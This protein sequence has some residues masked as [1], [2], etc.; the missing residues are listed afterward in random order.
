M[1]YWQRV[2]EHYCFAAI[3]VCLI[4]IT[5]KM[6]PPKILVLRLFCIDYCFAEILV[7]L[8]IIKFKMY[9]PKILVLRLFCIEIRSCKPIFIYHPRYQ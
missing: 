7:C 6:Y 2:N 1:S 3:L 8:I 9:S 5:F 4:I